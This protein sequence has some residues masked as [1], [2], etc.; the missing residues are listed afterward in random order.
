MKKRNILIIVVATLV[1]VMTLAIV[2]VR[3]DHNYG[4]RKTDYE[5]RATEVG[6]LRAKS[7]CL[8]EQRGDALCESL[9]S[10]V[11]DIECSNGYTC[12]VVYVRSRIPHEFQASVTVERV[13]VKSN[14]DTRS[15]QATGYVRSP[16]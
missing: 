1:L 6:L 12:W 15:L 5:R 13:D 7:E 4:I 11:S 10:D 2:Y 8:K 14:P 16:E 9:T 3:L